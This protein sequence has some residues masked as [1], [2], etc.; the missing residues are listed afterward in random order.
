MGRFPFP[1]S[2]ELAARPLNGRGERC[3]RGTLSEMVRVHGPRSRRT[4]SLSA[5]GQSLDRR[6]CFTSRSLSGADQLRLTSKLPRSN[7]TP[8]SW[9]L[10]CHSTEF[11]L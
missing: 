3:R 10:P 7:E 8:T 1:L 9:K 4:Q 6:A 11:P 5:Q 2:P